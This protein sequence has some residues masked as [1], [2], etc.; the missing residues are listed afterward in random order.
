MPLLIQ[1]NSEILPF[2]KGIVYGLKMP[3]DAL[4]FAFRGWPIKPPL[5]LPLL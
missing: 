4:G 1:R 2:Q 3:Q 5:P